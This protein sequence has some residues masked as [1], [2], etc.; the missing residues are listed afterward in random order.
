MSEDIADRYLEGIRLFN[1]EEFFECHDVLEEIWSDCQ[2]EEKS[3]LQGLIQA[4][5][6]LF[7]FGNENYGGAKKLYAT[8]LKRL[9]VYGDEYMGIQL[10]RFR[11]DF[12]KCF[13]ELIGSAEAYPTGL[14]VQD[15]L[16]PKIHFTDTP[17]S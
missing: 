13:A 5:V 15:D 7:H 10:A 11:D 6:A 16:V 9:D 14:L 2:G 12:R 8:S 1:E 17:G 4:S 3:F